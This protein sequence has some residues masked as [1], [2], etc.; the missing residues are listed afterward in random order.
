M[1]SP[2]SHLHSHVVPVSPLYSHVVLKQSLAWSCGALSVPCIAMWSSNS[3]LHGHV[4]PCQSHA[5]TC[6]ALSVISTVIV[7]LVLNPDLLCAVPAIL[8]GPFA[9]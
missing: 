6:G 5:W 4:V 9:N 1:W 3:H 8:A 2:I 7:P